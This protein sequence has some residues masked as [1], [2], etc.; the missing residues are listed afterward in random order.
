MGN[1]ADVGL[2]LGTVVAEAMSVAVA[3]APFAAMVG[4]AAFVAA[5]VATGAG[6]GGTRVGKA[7]TVIDS[8]GRLAMGTLGA[9]MVTGGLG[10]C[11]VQL[12]PMLANATPMMAHL[13]MG[14]L[15]LCILDRYRVFAKINIRIFSIKSG[16]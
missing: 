10:V 2:S 8:I 1:T 5:I 12:A 13:A 11:R 14:V 3:F 6:V 7:V 4:K 16:N 9:V 15:N